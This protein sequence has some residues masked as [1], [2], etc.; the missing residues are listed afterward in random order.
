MSRLEDN[1]KYEQEIDRLNKELDE[2]NS[3]YKKACDDL[4][5]NGT[6]I[7]N[8]GVQLTEKDKEITKLGSMHEYVSRKLEIAHKRINDLYQQWHDEKNK[9]TQLFNTLKERDSQLN[10]RD[11]LISKLRGELNYS[12][13]TAYHE[14]AVRK[15]A[16]LPKSPG[17]TARGFAIGT[18]TNSVIDAYQA[19]FAEY[20]D[21]IDKR[22]AEIM[23]L[24]NRLQF[25]IEQRKV[26]DVQ[27]TEGQERIRVLQSQLN[28]CNDQFNE[29]M[30]YP[31]EPA[32]VSDVPASPFETQL[33]DD[34]H[35]I[36]DMLVQKNRSYGNSALD[37]VRVFSQA[38]P[39]EQI[40]VRI[41]DKLS[42]VKRGAEFQGEDTI[43]DL[44]G[45]FFLFLQAKRNPAVKQEYETGIESNL[46]SNH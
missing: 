29:A 11:A 17:E 4:G 26:R 18:T 30:K 35:G 41:D 8:M 37:P 19:R 40:L 6:T 10:E 13:M 21:N 28:K 31:G 2:V 5:K 32:R 16:N 25:A 44:I 43:R 7:H 34:M 14:D 36:Y 20:Q 15:E 24:K 1:L 9:Q 12:N 42:R 3:L 38:S 45:Y 23:D 27:L 39:I 33:S 22:D 46:P